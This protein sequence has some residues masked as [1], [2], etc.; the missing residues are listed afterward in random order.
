MPP[1]DFLIV[2]WQRIVV[3]TGRR[4][5]VLGIHE[6]YVLVWFLVRT[7]DSAMPQGL[8][9]SG[10]D[11]PEASCAPMHAAVSPER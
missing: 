6:Q 7:V 11:E 10:A 1:D 5:S 8:I 2:D 4:A 3:S 9:A